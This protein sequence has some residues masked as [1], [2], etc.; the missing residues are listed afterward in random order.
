MV[1]AVASGY[2]Q[3]EGGPAKPTIR[4][5]LQEERKS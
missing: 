5:K 1:K 2:V 3:R 4:E